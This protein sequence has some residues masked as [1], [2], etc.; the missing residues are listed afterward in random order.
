LAP[1]LPLLALDS[2]F[3]VFVSSRMG[4]DKGTSHGKKKSLRHDPLHV[5][6]QQEDPRYVAD[7]D[8]ARGAVRREK[9]KQQETK[10][11][12]KDTDKFVSEKMSKKILEQARRQQEEIEEEEDPG[13]RKRSENM[14]LLLL[15]WF[16]DMSILC[17]CC[18]GVRIARLRPLRDQAGWRRTTMMMKMRM[19]RMIV[20]RR[21]RRALMTDLRGTSL[22]VTLLVLLS[23]L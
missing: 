2:N 5:Q 22:Y 16:A 15:V 4:K 3:F 23:S 20:T 17:V 14:R 7:Q 21:M 1:F 6:I 11:S 10:A 9:A 19:A 8:T 18:A 12:M 13:L